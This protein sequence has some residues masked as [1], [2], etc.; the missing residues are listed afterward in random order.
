[1]A[2][3]IPTFDRRDLVFV[4]AFLVTLVAA[5]GVLRRAA[6]DPLT[7][8]LAVMVAIVLTVGT[9]FYMTVEEWN[10]LDSLYFTVVTL[11]TVGFGDFA[12]ETD[13]GKIFTILYIFIGVGLLLGFA[14]AIVERSRF[15]ARLEGEAANT[16]DRPIES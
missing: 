6:F 10:F 3:G 13:L 7:R 9:I 15:W 16:E 4:V 1:M 5:A 8:G 11:T 12:P 2:D 14:T